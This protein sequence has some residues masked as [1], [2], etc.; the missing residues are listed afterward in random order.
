MEGRGSRYCVHKAGKRGLSPSHEQ[1]RQLWEEHL[2]KW[3]ENRTQLEIGDYSHQRTENISIQDCHLGCCRKEV[4]RFT[5]R[6]SE[7]SYGL[8]LQ[9]VSRILK[10]TE[11][12]GVD[13]I[14]LDKIH[15]SNGREP[16]TEL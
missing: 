12:G 1:G 6:N 3:F 7:G 4:V 9:V 2:K 14:T 15:S 13:E 16:S 5:A 8:Y 10:V 11:T